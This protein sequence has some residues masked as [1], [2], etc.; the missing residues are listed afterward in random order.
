MKKNQKIQ[1]QSIFTIQ[2][3]VSRVKVNKKLSLGG[4]IVTKQNWKFPMISND[5]ICGFF[6]AVHLVALG[7]TWSKFSLK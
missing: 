4:Y 6:V 2:K 1:D 3:S 5:G 7:K